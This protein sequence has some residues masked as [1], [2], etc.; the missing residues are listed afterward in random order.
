MESGN[1]EKLLEK[2]FEAETT[3]AEEKELRHY[4]QEAEVAMNL[5]E[6]APLFLTFS[7]S[8]K[9]ELKTEIKVTQAQNF[10]SKWMRI[11]ASIAI[12]I[13]LYFGNSY[14]RQKQAE[15]A[16][17]QTRMALN[18]IARNLDRGTAKVARM[19]TFEDTKQKLYRIP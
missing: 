14:R 12:I 10:S 19:Q 16:Y 9:E 11:A 2:Y 6:Y 15:Y 1:I 13:G 8:K 5:R 17:Q 4:F 18:L 3:L 7:V